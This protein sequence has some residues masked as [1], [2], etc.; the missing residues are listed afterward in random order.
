[1]SD[2]AAYEQAP[3]YKVADATYDGMSANL[4]RDGI[5]THTIWCPIAERANSAARQLAHILN[6]SVVAG[7]EIE[8]VN[9]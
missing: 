7:E 9:A 8:V 4:W 5:H 2:K 1:M 6:R 3:Q